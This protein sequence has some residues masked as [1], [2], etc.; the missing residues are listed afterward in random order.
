MRSLYSL[1]L[2]KEYINVAS[3]DAIRSACTPLFDN[4]FID[5]FIYYRYYKTGETVYIDTNSDF[6]YQYHLNNNINLPEFIVNFIESYSNNGYLGAF[7]DEG[8]PLIQGLGSLERVN[9]YCSLAKGLGIN[10][11]FVLA[12][13]FNSYYELA[14]FGTGNNDPQLLYQYLPN[15]EALEKFI[16]YFRIK[17]APL[18]EKIKRESLIP[19]IILPT[20]EMGSKTEY[21][22][23][24]LLHNI[25]LSKIPIDDT[26]LTRQEVKVLINTTVKGMTAKNTALLLG[27]S[28]RTIE[29]HLQNIKLKL[30]CNYKNELMAKCQEHNIDHSL[31]DLF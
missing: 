2:P 15:K 10:N 19:K 12:K 26:Y 8:T 29:D 31:L 7:Y 4:S 1:I 3:G 22:M 6:L 28:F 30:S 16:A 20:Y 14:Q 25:K 9:H 23:Q 21:C 18:I 13:Q 17:M 11:I 24:K 5:H 27:V